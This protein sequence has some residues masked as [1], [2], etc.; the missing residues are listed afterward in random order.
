M[1]DLRNLQT[2]VDIG[3]SHPNYRDIAAIPDDMRFALLNDLE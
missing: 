3:I 1:A 2:R